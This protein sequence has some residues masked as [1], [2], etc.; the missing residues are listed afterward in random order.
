MKPSNYG[1]TQ[2]GMVART[3]ARTQT[4]KH[5]ARESSQHYQHHNLD[6][7]QRQ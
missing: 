2:E 4:T 7:Q 6:E 1:N 5:K 3:N